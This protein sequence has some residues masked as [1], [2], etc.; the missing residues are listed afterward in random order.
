MSTITP[1]DPPTRELPWPPV[2]LLATVDDESR[3]VLDSELRRRY[4]TD[5]EVVT[6]VGYDHARAVLEGLRRLHRDVAMVVSGY[7]PDDR[8]GLSFLRRA[9]SIHPS[10]KRVVVVRWGDFESAAPVFRAIADGHAELQVVRPERRRD[11]EFHG[12]ITDVLD[13]WHLAQGDGFEA[14]RIIGHHD[15][16]TAVLRDAFSRNHIPVGFYPADSEAGRRLLAGMDL[17]DPALPV[18]VLQFR[19]PPITL[20]DPTDVE[21]A[22]AFALMRPPSADQVYDVVVVGAGPGGLATAVY[23]ASEGL[24]T[25]VIE[26]LAIGGQAGTSSLI[27]NYPGFARGISGAH[28]A[29]RT[30][31]QAWSFGAEFYFLREVTELQTVGDEHVLQLSDGSA[32]RSRS[33]VVATGVDYRRLGIAGLDDLVGRGVFYGA[34]VSEAPAMAGHAA[35]VVGGGNSAGQAALHLAR[36]AR[37]VTL[38]VRTADL[39]SSMSEYLIEQL[40]ST[41]NIDVRYRV[42][43]VGGNAVD[44]AL[45]E[46]EIFH[47]DEGT[48]EVISATGLFV[49]IGATPHTDWL[50]QDVQRNNEAFVVVG[51]DVDRGATHDPLRVPLP[52]ETSLPGVFAIGDARAGSVKRVA[53]AVGDAPAVVA[54]VRQ[55]VSTPRVGVSSAR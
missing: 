11:E 24:S 37:H 19:S 54:S 40:H 30:F 39:E 31:Q 55:H 45:A 41:R 10:A 2:I 22:D 5:Y 9:R 6:S 18:I 25:L 20:V 16:R 44:D 43:V 34:T 12:A 28:L 36:Y 3:A 32:V 27:R 53:T 14:V 38:L 13:D 4:S 1:S 7:G 29:I 17:S 51:N 33:V 35:F 8:D 26:R 49:F 46:L 42:A 47:L 52:L 50:G 23:A 21:L 48:T 15:E